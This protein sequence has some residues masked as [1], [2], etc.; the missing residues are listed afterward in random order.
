MY[1]GVGGSFLDNYA[2]RSLYVTDGTTG[3]SFQ[4]VD[5]TGAVMDGVR[6]AGF[7]ALGDRLVFARLGLTGEEDL[8]ITDGTSQGTKLVVDFPATGGELSLETA[9]DRLFFSRRVLGKN[10]FEL[11]ISDGTSAG[12]VQVATI[13]SK[14][15]FSQ[16]AAL[17]LD[18]LGFQ[19]RVVF[20]AR[21]EA[22]FEPWV[23]DGT[24]AGTRRWA[25]LN[26]GPASSLGGSSI[27]NIVQVGNRVLLRAN[28][29]EFGV[30]PVSLPASVVGGWAKT[31][32][33]EACSG[34]FGKPRIDASGDGTTGGQLELRVENAFPGGLAAIFV[35]TDF[36][37][38]IGVGLCS[39][40]VSAPVLLGGTSVDSDGVARLVLNVPSQVALIDRE[41][42]LQ[43]IA[44]ELNAPF[45]GFATLTGALELVIAE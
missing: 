11:W 34:V 24:P 15:G 13:D 25:D 29:A 40:Q 31:H 5:D 30:E 6:S 16:T 28:S 33:G 41:L 1:F 35:G 2:S 22:G 7:E 44:A 45:G 3:G 8:W 17:T 20:R 39:A 21:D 23:S 37:P 36:I 14:V 18:S 4:L 27:S 19:D 32:L 38:A 26:P 10:L 12:T 9:G 43:A 42:F